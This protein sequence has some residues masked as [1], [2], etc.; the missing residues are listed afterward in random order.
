MYNKKVLDHFNNPR[1]QGIIKDADGVGQ[2]G[3]PVCGDIMK[4]YI[5]IDQNK[6]NQE[7]IKDIKFETLGCG[8]AIA[9]SSI[10]TEMAKGKTIKMASKI[11]KLDIAKKLGGLPKPKLH[12]SILAHEGL[13]EAIKN[14]NNKKNKK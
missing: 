14:Y 2:V 6:K 3:N 9:T 12:C 8:A 5:R 1:N 11:G 10:L 7:I 13:A 4:I